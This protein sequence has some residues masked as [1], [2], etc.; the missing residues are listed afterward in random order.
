MYNTAIYEHTIEKNSDIMDHLFF[1][2]KSFKLKSLI[3][4]LHYLEDNQVSIIVSNK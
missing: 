4:F 1:I 2:I 3:T